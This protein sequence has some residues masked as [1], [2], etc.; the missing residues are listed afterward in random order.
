[1][2]DSSAAIVTQ[3]TCVFLFASRPLATDTVFPP[4]CPAAEWLVLEVGEEEKNK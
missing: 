2:Q 4:G 1:M 3:L